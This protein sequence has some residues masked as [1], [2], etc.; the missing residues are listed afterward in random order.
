M[1]VNSTRSISYPSNSLV[2]LI[3]D[4]FSTSPDTDDF[5]RL[6]GYTLSYLSKGTTAFEYQEIIKKFCAGQSFSAK[7]FR[8]RLHTTKYI[9]LTLKLFILRLSS[10]R[11]TSTDEAKAIGKELG[12]CNSDAKRIYEFWGTHRK[13][14]ARLKSLYRAIPKESRIY[15]L[16]S[17]LQKYF[18]AIYASVYKYVKYI[19]YTKLRFIAKSSNL[20]LADLHNDIITKVLQTFYALVPIV[21]PEAHVVN[22]L[23]RAA[24]N[25]AINII[26]TETTQKKGRLVSTGFDHENN[27]TFSLLMVSENQMAATVDSENTPYDEVHNDG[28][29]SLANFELEFSVAEI[30]TKLKQ[31]GKKV[32][33]LKILMGNE[34]QEFTDW[35]RLRGKC[36][37]ESDNVDVQNKVAIKEYNM[38][39]SEFLHVSEDK[40]NVFLFSLRKDLALEFKTSKAS[41]DTRSR[42]IPI[43]RLRA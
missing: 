15:L 38:L 31:R 5:N 21:T 25:H 19:T 10:T 13:F 42:Q 23:K 34:D 32:R 28:T 37:P 20:E 41:L 26:K 12:V 2:H 8:L 18:A 29:N 33:L 9:A 1:S 7:V 16:D 39:V 4:S 14:K 30:L 3:S 40:L 11:S 6:Y 35:L 24:H 17:E 43:M 27:R 22:Y 36:T